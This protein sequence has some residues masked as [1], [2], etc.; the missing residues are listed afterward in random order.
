[1]PSFE[2]HLHGAIR[3]VTGT[4]SV[5]I[6]QSS[7]FLPIHLKTT[8]PFR[9]P[10]RARTGPAESREPCWGQV[11]VNVPVMVALVMGTVRQF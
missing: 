10:G 11:M 6:G 2:A 4:Y 5:D 7:G 8:A 9:A 1:M 3:T